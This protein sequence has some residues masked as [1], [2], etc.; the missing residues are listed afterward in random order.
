MQHVLEVAGEGELE[1]RLTDKTRKMGVLRSPRRDVACP[2]SPWDSRYRGFAGCE[3][4]QDGGDGACE[5]VAGEGEIP[6]RGGA[7]RLDGDAGRRECTGEA[8][9]ERSSRRWRWPS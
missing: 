4:K 2:V 7:E 1:K 9:A 6:E 3:V 5:G 8:L